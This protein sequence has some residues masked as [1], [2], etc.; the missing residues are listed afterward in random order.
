MSDSFGVDTQSYLIPI[1]PIV[2]P[3]GSSKGT[4]S[5]KLATD[6]NLHHSLVGDWLRES[7]R[8]LIAGVLALINRYISKARKF[9]RTY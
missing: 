7:A 1:I 9:R 8:P 3:P 2:G 6:F 4:L 5:K